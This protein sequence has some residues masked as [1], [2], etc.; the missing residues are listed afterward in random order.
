MILISTGFSQAL[1]TASLFRPPFLS[2]GHPFGK[3]QSLEVS[4]ELSLCRAQSKFSAEF[5]VVTEK[6]LC[7][8]Q[9]LGSRI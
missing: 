1:L 4:I 2:A 9:D 7:S 3:N 6:S 8:L 5:L